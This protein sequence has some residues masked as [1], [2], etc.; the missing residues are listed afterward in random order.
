MQE[1]D[2]KNWVLRILLGAYDVYGVSGW[3]S[4][5]LS[6]SRLLALGLATGVIAQ[7]I[8]MMGSMGGKSVVGAIM[9][10]IVFIVGHALNFAIN[11]LGAYV[12]T[13]RL[14]FVEFF[15]KFYEGGGRPFKAF[16][17]A[18]KYTE[19]KEER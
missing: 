4:D 3:L 10:I 18:N 11:V 1:R 6:Y 17:T 14:Q 5:V 2:K 8:N 7:V 13:N 9:F 12:H 15:G 16:Q 19:I